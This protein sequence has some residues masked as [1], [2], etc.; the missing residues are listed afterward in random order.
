MKITF[1]DSDH[2]KYKKKRRSRSSK[3]AKQKSLSPL[4]KRMA[5]LTGELSGPGVGDLALNSY[6]FNQSFGIVP[7]VPSGEPDEYEMR[8]GSMRKCAYR[9]RN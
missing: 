9:I 2:S 6:S 8:V 1:S 4:S 5:L 3:V 7:P